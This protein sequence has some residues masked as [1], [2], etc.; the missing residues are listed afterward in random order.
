MPLI[1]SE[2]IAIELPQHDRPE[3]IP[4]QPSTNDEH[5]TSITLSEMHFHGTQAWAP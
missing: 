2:A 5:L 3:H 1:T 4:N